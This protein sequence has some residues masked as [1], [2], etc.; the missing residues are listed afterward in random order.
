MKEVNKQR[1]E[2]LSWDEYFMS[3]AKLSALRSKDPNTQVGACIV[4]DDNRILSIGYN[5]APNGY[6]DKFFPWD[7]EGNP[8]DTKYLYVCHAE[9][10]AIL[11]F[12]GSKKD[13]EGA[14]IYVDLFPCNECAK[15]I[16]QSGIKKVIYLCD[17]Y[18][19][20]DN[21]IAS[22]RLFDECGV[23]YEL[24]TDIKTK[25]LTLELK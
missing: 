14:K 12:R 6:E 18:K 4:S 11:N 3:I 24:L 15:M 1:K 7:R 21:F 9:M 8:L 25:S 16:I 23:S 17:K 19:D 5:G 13:L 20:Q 2:Y 22:K 10:N